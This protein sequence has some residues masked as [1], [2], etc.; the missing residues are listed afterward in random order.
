MP[1]GRSKG[2]GGTGSRDVGALVGAFEEL[3]DLSEI[4]GEVRFKVVAYHRA[5]ETIRDLGDEVFEYDTMAG[6]KKLPGIGEGIARKIL[7]FRE[8][9]RIDA[10]ERLK[11]EVPPEL[12]SLLDVPNLGPK[13]ARLVFDELGVRSLDDLRQAAEDHR[14][15]G[16]KGLGPKAEANILEGLDNLQAILGPHAHQPGL[17]PG[18]RRSSRPCGSGCPAST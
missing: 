13:R 16:L 6:L 9:G 3:A 2:S 17:R 5:A 8:E 14:L 12:I 7:Q 11:E 1:E 4:K 15:A 10:L 18:R